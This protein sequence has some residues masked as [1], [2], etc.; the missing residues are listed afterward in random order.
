MPR[1]LLYLLSMLALRG[2]LADVVEASREAVVLG[3]FA[4]EALDGLRRAFDCIWAASPTA[5]TTA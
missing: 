5:R 1:E 3:E 2:A 4:R